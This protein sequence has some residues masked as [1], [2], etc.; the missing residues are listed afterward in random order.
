MSVGNACKEMRQHH[1]WHSVPSTWPLYINGY[2]PKKKYS[3]CVDTSEHIL[4]S[5]NGR[6]IQQRVPIQGTN[7]RTI[8]VRKHHTCSV[9]LLWFT[10]WSK[11][12]QPQKQQGLSCSTHRSCS[13]SGQGLRSV[14][15][16]SQQI[17]ST[18]KL[19]TLQCST[20]ANK[21]RGGLACSV[22]WWLQRPIPNSRLHS[23]HV[24]TLFQRAFGRSL[25]RAAVTFWLHN[26][27]KHIH[28]SLL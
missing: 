4:T 6:R 28:R 16:P 11:T 21:H 22:I 14:P 23:R 9:L 24:C 8:L 25:S 12:K 20:T 1:K 2:N 17:S 18:Q 15:S 27:P 7:L 26:L 3:D 10:Q 13:L 19:T 5:T